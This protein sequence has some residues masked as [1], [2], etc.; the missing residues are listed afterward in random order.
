L[1]GCID[2]CEKLS[3]LS[4]S[5]FRGCLLGL[6]IGDAIG[7]SV[8]FMPPGSFAPLTDMIGGGPFNLI[9]GEWTDDTSMALCLADSLIEKAGF[10]PIDQLERYVRWY[11]AGYL[12]S[13]G[14]CFDIG[15]T[16]CDSLHRFERTHEPFPGPTAPHTAGS[17][18]LMRLAPVPMF[19]AQYP[20]QAIER[21]ADSSR[22]THA[23]IKAVDACRYFGAL[24]VGA[25]NSCPREALLRPIS[26][27]QF[28]DSKTK[29]L[30]SSLSP[31]IAEIA[32]GSFMHKQPP[33]IQG[34]GYVVRGLEAV[35]WAFYNSS[36]FR[37]GVLMAANLGD[38]A[39]T[40]AAI[41]GQ[42]AGAYYG[43]ENIPSEWRSRLAQGD[44]IINFADKLWEAAHSL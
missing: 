24:L 10:D 43:E 21:C 4:Q 26:T 37:E 9:P 30:L 6:A 33:G 5:R 18:S 36:S 38:D 2:L 16:T 44:M 11:R 39:D 15:I 22:T 19:Y 28:L 42:L 31:E 8:E 17:G 13:N 23:N 12:S 40:T 35:L 20:Q 34:S 27:W 14:R 29:A 1:K 32:N 7:T 41:Y 25:L 3:P